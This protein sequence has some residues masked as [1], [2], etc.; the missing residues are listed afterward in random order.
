T[1][2]SVDVDRTAPVITPTVQGRPNGA[3][4]Y[5]TAP[6]VTFQ[7]ADAVSAVALCPAAQVVSTDGTG[8]VV[9][10][11]A[12]DRAGNTASAEVKVNVDRTAPVTTVVGV[13]EGAVYASDAVP[14][15]SCRTTD[16][17]SG[18]A[19]EPKPLVTTAANG[20]Q[21]VLCA[22]AVDKAGNQG[23][24]AAVTYTVTT[25]LGTLRDL[26]HEYLAGAPA[27]TVQTFDKA[28]DKRNLVPYMAEVIIHSSGRKAVLTQKQ[29]ATLLS[30]A[31][32]LDA[33]R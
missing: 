33:R 5:N 2:V 16:Q 12:A 29:A 27:A 31:V 17:G 1:Q 23:A 7:C 21:T 15:A 30:W 4:W 20:K 8:T 10:G 14:T 3:G 9:A 13:A 28:L 18:A 19:L 6:T 26:T 24:D 11:D 22:A 32:V 25:S